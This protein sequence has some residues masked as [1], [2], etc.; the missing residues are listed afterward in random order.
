MMFGPDICGSDK[1]THV[2]FNYKD[3]NHLIKKTISP[4]SDQL[5]REFFQLFQF[6]FLKKKDLYTLIVYPNQTYTVKIDGEKKESG[7]F[8]DDWP[9]LPPKMIA[10]PKA[11]KPEDWQGM[12]KNTCVFL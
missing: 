7:S 2:I 3:K 6:F 12:S 4:E 9:F 8:F 11:K 1:K 10:D 5:T